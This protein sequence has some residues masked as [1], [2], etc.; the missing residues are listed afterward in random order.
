MCKHF[1]QDVSENDAESLNSND[2][3]VQESDDEDFIRCSN[4]RWLWWTEIALKLLLWFIVWEVFV[5]LQFG[6]VYFLVS[7]FIFIG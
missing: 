7:C 3:E 2:T 1:L 5:L 6:A 4:G